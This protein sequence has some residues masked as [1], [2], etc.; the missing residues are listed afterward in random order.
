ME[1]PTGVTVLAVLSFIGAAFSILGALGTFL[2]GGLGMA[3]MGGQRPGMGMLMA[4]MGAFAGVIFLCLA[5]LYAIVGVGLWK[6]LGWG[7]ILAIMLVGAGMVFALMGLFSAVI[8]FRILL[9]LW[10]IIVVA[11]DV[12]IL[13]YLTRP[14]VKQAFAQ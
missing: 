10:Q 9:A 2:L 5:A 11:I 13:W 3:T 4:G 1:R 14:H 7:R 12:W 6:L 8:H